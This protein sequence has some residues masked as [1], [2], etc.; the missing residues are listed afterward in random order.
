MKEQSTYTDGLRK[1][2]KYHLIEVN[3]KFE[4]LVMQ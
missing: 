4:S 2:N 1:L 3:Y